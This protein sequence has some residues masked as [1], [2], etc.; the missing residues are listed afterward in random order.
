MTRN[1]RRY[2]FYIPPVCAAIGT[3]VL[4][5]FTVPSHA[6][7]RFQNQPPLSTSGLPN[8]DALPQHLPKP[9]PLSLFRRQSLIFQCILTA[10]QAPHQRCNLF[11][12]DVELCT[13]P[14]VKA[15][16]L[17][18]RR[19]EA[20]EFLRTHHPGNER[21]VY[22]ALRFKVMGMAVVGHQAMAIQL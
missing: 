10:G 18:R 22:H 20:Y 16:F 19:M 1:D 14:N 12:G 3:G 9:F 17:P 11:N 15:Q 2:D 13:H 7:S 4:C 8:G 6:S 21:I 5:V